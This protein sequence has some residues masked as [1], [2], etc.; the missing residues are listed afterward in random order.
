MSNSKD[1]K[2]KNPEYDEPIS[3]YEEGQT[4]EDVVRKMLEVKPDQQENESSGN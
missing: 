3:V 4:P 1:D 2:R